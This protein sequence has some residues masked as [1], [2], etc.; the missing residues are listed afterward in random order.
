MNC[1][2]PFFLLFRRSPFSR[3]RDNCLP[4]TL[5]RAESQANNLHKHKYIRVYTIDYTVQTHTQHMCCRARNGTTKSLLR[6][7]TE[8]K[9][10]TVHADAGP[11]GVKM[12]GM[13][14]GTCIKCYFLT[15][16]QTHTHIG[17]GGVQRT[18]GGKQ[19]F[20]RVLMLKQKAKILFGQI[21][22]LSSKE[23]LKQHTNSKSGSHK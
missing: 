3:V 17:H 23:H 6:N 20:Y 12:D 11:S 7:E 4:S 8:L 1:K 2:L 22:V 15:H 21:V 19:G 16:S 14:A 9:S 10:I 18:H 5:P 13:C